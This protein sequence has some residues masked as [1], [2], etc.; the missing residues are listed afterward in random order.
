MRMA[1]TSVGTTRTDSTSDAAMTGHAPW[2]TIP[3]PFRW[4]IVVPLVAG[5]L[6]HADT[7]QV[8]AVW[9]V[10]DAVALTAAAWFL[11]RFLRERGASAAS[12]LLGAVLF[13]A[14]WVILRYA[15][16]VLIDAASYAVLAA[17]AYA[18]AARRTAL[19]AVVMTVGMFVKET[20]A[21]ALVLIVLLDHPWAVRARQLAVGLPGVL[22]YVVFRLLT[23]TDQGYAYSVGRIVE[24][25]R[26]LGSAHG[27]VLAVAQGV[28]TFGPLWLLAAIGWR[29]RALLPRRTAWLVPLVLVVPY[30]IG[31]NLAR[32]WFLAFPVVIPF[33]VVG[34]DALLSRANGHEPAPVSATSATE[35]S[36]R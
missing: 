13:F 32:V 20:T 7:A 31:S 14:S 8:Q 4:R 9:G 1:P 25:V 17:A 12:A 34:V 33:A 30:L 22:G 35:S 2:A 3:K 15:G 24:A 11:H 23:P 16:G 21:L 29:A 5:L 26:T 36:S 28:L 10:I 6:P 18:S 27:L 19:L